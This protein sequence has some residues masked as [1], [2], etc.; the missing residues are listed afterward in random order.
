MISWKKWKIHP[1]KKMERRVRG[2]FTPD[3]L[4]K[5]ARLFGA[6]VK[7]ALLLS[8]MENFV[9]SC[10]SAKGQLIL[11]ITHH[12]HRSTDELLGELDWMAYLSRGGVPLALPFQSIH[13]NLVEQVGIGE[14]RFVVTAFPKLPGQTILEAHECTPEIF[15]QWGR[16]MG[17]MHTLS[18][19]Y[20]P[21]IPSYRRFTW[22]E[23]DIFVNAGKYID[24]QSMILCKMQKLIADLQGLPQDRESYGLVHRDFTD[25]NFLVNDHRIAVIDFDD[26]EYHWFIYDIAI[27]LFDSLP[28]LPHQE[29]D[30][31]CFGKY[32]W[33]YFYNGYTQENRLDDSWLERLPQFIKLCQIFMYIWFHK[34]WDQDKLTEGRKSVI[35]RYKE[36][37]ENDVPCLG[38]NPALDRS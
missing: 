10:D 29:M 34:K 27:V 7:S 21:T 6:D 14:S 24:G 35:A 28:F 38:F 31:G 11:R 4:Y 18:K 20:H 30:E 9:Y 15:H 17:K 37:I 32:F 19:D 2:L 33:H 23:N 5:S 16:I 13:G 1:D 3:L 25:V 12:S 36:N 22:I 26:A 8:E